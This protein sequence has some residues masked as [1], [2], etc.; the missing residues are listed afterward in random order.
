MPH[1]DTAGSRSNYWRQ[2]IEAWQSSGQTQRAFCRDHD[3]NYWR[4]GY[5]RKKFRQTADRTT[6]PNDSAFVAV[7]HQASQVNDELSLTFPNGVV[8]RGIGSDNVAIVGQLLRQ[9]S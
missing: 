6:K 7:V 9:L 3:L 8:I 1:N 5:W 4:F 2:Q